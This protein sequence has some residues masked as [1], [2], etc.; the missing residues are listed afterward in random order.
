MLSSFFSSSFTRNADTLICASGMEQAVGA[1]SSSAVAD[2]IPTYEWE[3]FAFD[4]S[5]SQ[6]GTKVFK[7]FPKLSYVGCPL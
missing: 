4:L 3:P 6:S 1:A 7:S 2:V 5:V